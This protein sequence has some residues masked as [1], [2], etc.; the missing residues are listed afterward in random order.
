M[1]NTCVITMKAR[2]KRSNSVEVKC[3]ERRHDYI[4]IG[5]AGAH[6]LLALPA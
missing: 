4:T 5:F 3:P 2:I 1:A 6:L